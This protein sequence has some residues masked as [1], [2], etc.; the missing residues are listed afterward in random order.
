MADILSHLR[1]LARH[2]QSCRNRAPLN[3][4]ANWDAKIVELDAIIARYEAQ[5][6][7]FEIQLDDGRFVVV[8]KD[9]HD[10]WNGTRRT[11]QR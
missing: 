8:S 1:F 7:Q 6:M 3:T 2:Y 11:T 9:V 10:M 5:S 4:A